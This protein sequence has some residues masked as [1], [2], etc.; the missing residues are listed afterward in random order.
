MDR[1]K[2]RNGKHLPVEL[3]KYEKVTMHYL[4]MVALFL[5]LSDGFA[6]FVT[7]Q[8][9]FNRKLFIS[10]VVLFLVLLFSIVLRVV[11]VGKTPYKPGFFYALMKTSDILLL[12][13][14]VTTTRYGFLF[15]FVI[16]LPIISICISRGFAATLP[17]ICFSYVA[18]IIILYGRL[19]NHHDALKNVF[20][21]Q[22]QLWRLAFLTALYL[23]FTV[24]LRILGT[25]HDQFT[26]SEKDN[27]NLVDKLGRKYAQLE[28]ARKEKQDQ[29]DKLK[30]V[31]LQLEDTNKK[32]TSSIAEFFTLQ[33]ISQAISSIFD[34][35]ELLQF[36][37]DVIIGVM[38]V[39]TSNIALYDIGGERLKVQVSNIVHKKDRAILTDNINT[40]YLKDA[41]EHGRTIINNSVNPDEFDFT[42]GRNVR[43]LLCVPLQV[44][45]KSY[46]LVLIEHSIPEAFGEDNVRL[47]EII[48]QQ[49][50]IAI[51]NTRLY[52]QLQEFANTDGLTQIYNR[53]FF[54]NRLQDELKRAQQQG[55]EVSVILFD[56]DN[57]KRF[58]DSYGHL[59]GDIVLKTLAQMLKDSIRQD[60]IVARFGGEEFIILLPHTGMDF[61]FEKA[62]ELRNMIEK[63]T[64]RDKTISASVTVSM[65]VSTF[66]TLA[67]NE[68]VLLT[69]ADKALYKAKNS[70]KNCVRVANHNM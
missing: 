58:N 60:D 42:R 52:E 12:L 39:S 43:S 19:A 31:N 68:T 2:N 11:I 17:Y 5:I 20:F 38:G 62:E 54:Q 3:N 56:I 30:E 50:S 41:A 34:M 44:K 6:C 51:D 36:V 32:L 67:Q 45:G 35:N 8:A 25:Y 21:F 40:P 46:G 66:P 7:A 24:G 16:L 55:Y 10:Q 15:Y 1:C 29:Y 49:I 48:T 64:I 47:L 59:F 69:S 9:V 28:E 33:Q 27:R 26:Q 65:G 13:L 4:W 53:V 63:L 57:F 37:N 61:A 22:H 23:F 70:G 14:L 18:H